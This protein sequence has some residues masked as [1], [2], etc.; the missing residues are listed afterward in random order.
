MIDKVIDNTQNYV[1]SFPRDE[2]KTMGQFFTSINTARY[3]A[4]KVKAK[5]KIEILDVG[6]GT[7]ILSAALIEKL[8]RSRKTKV[9]HLTL[10]E[11]DERVILVLK[12]NL[13]FIRQVCKD[14]E[15]K[16]IVN[17]KQENF[18]VANS[19]FWNDKKKCKKYDVVIS[20]PPYM[21]IGK[22]DIEAKSMKDLIYG[23]PNI[24]YL[25]MAMGTHLLKDDGDFI[26]IVPRSWTSGLY[27]RSFRNYFFENIC[28]KSIHLFVSRDKVFDQESVLQET[29]IVYG[30]KSYKQ[31]LKICITA[32]EGTNDFDRLTKLYVKP[33]VCITQ[34]KNRF[35]LLPS[36]N[37]DIEVLNMMSNFQS[38]LKSLGYMF[39]TGQVVEFRSEKAVQVKYSR[40]CVPLLRPFHFSK[41]VIRFPVKTVKAQYMKLGDK[42]SLYMENKDMLLLKRFTTKEERRRLQPAIHQAVKT[43]QS[44]IAIENHVNYLEKI[45]GELEQE[46]LYGLWAILSTDSWDRYY[47]ILNGSTQV[48]ATEINSIP[49]PGIEIIREIG[50]RVEIKDESSNIEKL[51][52]EVINEQNRRN[53]R[54]TGGAPST[55]KTT[56]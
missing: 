43:K 29:M 23:Q 28:L 51:V 52:Q 16:L 18:I 50:K 9:I 54:Y 27:F 37:K 17:L 21:K 36:C 3:M 41:G 33:S 30:K 34:D 1:N 25:C 56:E 48:N 10:Y 2:R 40:G 35:L 6:A 53:A 8:L 55:K 26:F 7:G 14:K 20:N 49:I 15:I 11:N 24:Y 39:K 45:V 5:E 12:E 32:S 22:N 38:S 46:E 47:R 4:S 42:K 13:K 31:S 19:K 44:Y